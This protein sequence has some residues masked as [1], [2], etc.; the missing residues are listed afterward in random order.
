MTTLSNVA[1][2]ILDEHKYTSSDISLTNL[3]YL[4]DDVVDYVNLQAGLSISDLSGS[5]ESKSL[6][7][8]DGQI[9][10]IK[11]LAN[12]TIRAYKE[13]GTQA[14]LGGMSVTVIVN[15]LDSQT[16]RM[17]VSALNRLK[18]PPLYVSNDPVPTE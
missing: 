13:K 2:R 11:W 10:V 16:S 9:L 6:T 17:V 5:A 3:E 12:L 14:S 7:A 1:Q 8:T 4:I 18:D 15:D